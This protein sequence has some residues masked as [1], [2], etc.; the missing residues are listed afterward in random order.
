MLAT[1]G[2]DKFVKVFEV[3]SGK[4]LKSFEGHTHHVLDVGWKADGK[5]LASAGADNVVKVWDYEK[6]EQVRT[7]GTQARKQMTRLVFIGKTLGVRHVQRR[8]EGAQ[9]GTW[10]TAA[11]CTTSAAATISST[12][13]AS[14]PTAPSWRPAARRASSACTTERTAN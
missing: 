2:A 14:A 11:T 4:F 10:T 12:P 3:P 13:S 7:I 5:L 8:P 1:C 6:G 9:S